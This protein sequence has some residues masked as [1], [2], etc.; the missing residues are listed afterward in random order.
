EPSTIPV[1]VDEAAARFRSLAARRRLLVLLDNARSAEQVRPLLPGSTT[2]GVLVTS[3]QVLATLEGARCMHLDVLP[4]DQALQLLGRVTGSERVADE[5]EAAAEL[6]RR[7]GRLPL[8]VRIA[9]ARLVARPGWSIEELAERLADA[10]RRLEEL[11][12]GELAVRAS[13]EVSVR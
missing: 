12:A 3:R 1:K 2:C 8:A 13:F 6:V 7:C 9:G 11:Q 4:E 5:P 10:T